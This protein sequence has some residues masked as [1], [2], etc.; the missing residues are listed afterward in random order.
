MSRFLPVRLRVQ[1]ARSGQSVQALPK[2]ARPERLIGRVRPLGQVALRLSWSTVKSSTVN[3]PSN[4]RQARGESTRSVC[5]RAA[6]SA[7]N[8]PDP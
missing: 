8:S 2:K 6:S 7:R 4:G 5:P 1:R 3:P